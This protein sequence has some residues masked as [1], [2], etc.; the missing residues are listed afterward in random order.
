[1]DS[2]W[3]E[4]MYLFFGFLLVVVIILIVISSEMSIVFVYFHLAKYILYL[5][6]GEITNGGGEAYLCLEALHFMFLHMPSIIML[7]KKL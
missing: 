5:K 4:H 2:I 6:L 3:K 7:V 1:M